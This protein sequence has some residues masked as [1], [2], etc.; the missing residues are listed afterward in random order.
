MNISW[1]VSIRK[2]LKTVQKLNYKTP[3]RNTPF[4]NTKLDQ[5]NFQLENRQKWLNMVPEMLKLTCWALTHI[6]K[7]HRYL[8]FVFCLWKTAQTAYFCSKIYIFSIINPYFSGQFESIPTEYFFTGVYSKYV[9]LQWW[10]VRIPC[11]SSQVSLSND[12][13]ILLPPSP[14]S[15]FKFK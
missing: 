2:Y 10:R 14:L 11:F 6:K 9:Y 3:F 12:E 7:I 1:Q 4:C 13:V 15:N 8:P 5:K